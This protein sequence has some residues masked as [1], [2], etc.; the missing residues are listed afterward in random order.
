MSAHEAALNPR[1]Q[2]SP[3]IPCKACKSKASTCKHATACNSSVAG[4]NS[5]ARR[6]PLSLIGACSFSSTTFFMPM[7]GENHISSRSKYGNE[8]WWCSQEHVSLILTFPFSFVEQIA[9]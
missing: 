7:M 9:L 8:S 6:N 4:G 3:C 5:L 1:Q 2:P